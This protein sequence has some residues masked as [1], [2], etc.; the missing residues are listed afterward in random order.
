MLVLQ[1]LSPPWLTY[2]TV[3]GLGGN[4]VPADLHTIATRLATS[5][6]QQQARDD[7]R[8]ARLVGLD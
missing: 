2:P 7:S 4:V 5:A 3:R 6:A 1:T 8:P